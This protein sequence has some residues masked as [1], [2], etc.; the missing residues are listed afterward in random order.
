MAS[1]ILVIDD[2]KDM[3]ALLKRIIREETEHE[4]IIEHDP[5]KAM[6]HIKKRSFALV[7]TDLKMPRMNGIQ[8]MERIKTLR[9]DTPVVIMTAFGTID[10]AVDAV[11]RGAFDYITKPFS[12]ERIML[13]IERATTQG[14]DSEAMD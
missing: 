5:V 13:A 8:V 12:R 9:P 7:F 2:Q 11:R 4:V 10:T 14:A 3:L 1:G 6:D